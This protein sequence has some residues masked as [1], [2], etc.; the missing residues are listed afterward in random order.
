MAEAIQA[1]VAALP[2]EEQNRDL[3]ECGIFLRQ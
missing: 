3:Q 1:S 2:Q